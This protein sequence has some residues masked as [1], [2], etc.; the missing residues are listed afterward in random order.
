MH[1]KP[2][3]VEQVGLLVWHCLAHAVAIETQ[4]ATAWESLHLREVGAWTRPCVDAT[5]L[6]LSKELGSDYR[7]AIACRGGRSIRR[8]REDQLHQSDSS[9]GRRQGA[10]N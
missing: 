10:T 2:S 1:E 4:R 8:R 5:R 7:Y 6:G 9:C 3:R